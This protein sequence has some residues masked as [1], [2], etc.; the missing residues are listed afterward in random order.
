MTDLKTLTNKILED[1]GEPTVSDVTS[2]KG[3]QTVCVNGIQSTLDEMMQK[4]RRWPFLYTQQSQA[5]T[6]GTRKYSAPSG[7]MDLDWES[8]ILKAENIITNGTFVSNVN[9][10]T[11]SSTGTGSLAHTST[12][13]G[14]ARLAAGSSGVA[15]M[16]QS[17]TCTVS[18]KYVVN[19]RIFSGA[20]DLRIGTSAG[21]S[22]TLTQTLTIDN[23]G[24]GQFFTVPFTATAQTHHITFQHSTN[25][26][27]DVDFVEVREDMEIVNLREIKY[28]EYKRV[29]AK[30]DELPQVSSLGRP[31]RVYFTPNDE[32][33]FSPV[34]DQSSYIVEFDSWIE[35]TEISAN[36][37]AL[38]TPDDYDWV[39]EAG[40]KRHI[41]RRRG[42]RDALR[43]Y[44]E[45]FDEGLDLMINDLIG[46][47]PEYATAV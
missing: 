18:R 11:D 1:V 38:I 46:E 19:V 25:A 13:N 20:I 24:D 36:T 35:P 12:G 40:A 39:L 6:A 10:W 21:G 28:E 5:L 23:L 33:A 32:I 15:I 8:M 26:N 17:L 37:D 42:D 41:A 34:P 7:F 9:S 31:S 43:G 27:Y 2:T 30:T 14:R 47:F 29:Y 45:I 44:K 22:Q 16:T 3:I 4:G